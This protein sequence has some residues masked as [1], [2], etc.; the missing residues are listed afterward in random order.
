MIRSASISGV[1]NVSRVR[2]CARLSFQRALV[3]SL[4]VSEYAII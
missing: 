4:P 2:L 1:K 3:Q